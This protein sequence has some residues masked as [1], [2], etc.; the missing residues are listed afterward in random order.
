VAEQVDL[1]DSKALVDSEEELVMLVIFSNHSLAEHSVQVEEE[2]VIHLE[3]A[4]VELEMSV[5]MILKLQSHYHSWKLLPVH[6]GKSQSPPWS[7]VNH[8]LDL[9]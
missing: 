4:V 8:V 7:I 2:E 5:V 6:P 3:A 9:D 1:V